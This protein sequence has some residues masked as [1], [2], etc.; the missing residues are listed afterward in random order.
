MVKVTIWPAAASSVLWDVPAITSG[1][2]QALSKESAK[3]SD[4]PT[5]ITVDVPTVWRP[6]RG[7]YQAMWQNINDNPTDQLFAFSGATGA[8]IDVH[9]TFTLAGAVSTAVSYT[10]TSTI[11]LA[12]MAVGCLDVTNKITP[13]GYTGFNW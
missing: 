13:V 4:L 7:T 8:V 5:G 10:T 12:T 11:A 1:A 3:N 2:E 6:K 9:L